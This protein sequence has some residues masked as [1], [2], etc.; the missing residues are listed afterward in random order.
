MELKFHI[1]YQVLKRVDKK[2]VVDLSQDYLTCNFEFINSEWEGLPKYV[3]FTSSA[4]VN[5]LIYLGTGMDCTAYVPNQMLTGDKFKVT[6]YGFVGTYR[7]TTTQR[8]VII[9][10]SGYTPDI[11]PID[12]DVD[13][14]FFSQITSEIEELNTAVLTKADI[15]H[16]HDIEDVNNL[17]AILDSKASNGHQHVVSDVTDFEDTVGLDVK[18]ALNSIVNE[19]RT[20]GVDNND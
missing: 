2:T 7:I 13:E 6:V 14:D 9:V 10:P 20:Y 11:S 3:I 17:N 1:K 4:G 15:G 19:I 12:D 18:S 16:S 5:N 8:T